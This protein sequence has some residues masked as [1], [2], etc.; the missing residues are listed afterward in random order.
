VSK[1][2]AQKHLKHLETFASNFLAVLFNVYTQTLPE[3]RG[4]ILQCIDAYLS[5][6]PEA[7][8]VETF[9][10]V[11]VM[12]EGSLAETNGHSKGKSGKEK[13][14]Q[15][16]PLSS[17][18]MDLV[19]TIALY[20]PRSGMGQLF[21]LA[22]AMLN[23]AD[24]NLQK[25]AYKIVPR[26]AE[27]ESGKQALRERTEELQNLILGCSEK[28]QAAARRER[29]SSI[30]CLVQ[31]LPASDL[32][33]IPS[34]LPEVVLCT[35]EINEKTRTAAFE[36]LIAMGQVMQNGGTILNAKIPH[37]P[38]DAP[39]AVASIEEFLTMVSAGLAGTA[40]H[41]IS[42]CIA[43]LT[44]VV[45][46]FQESLS[47]E[48]LSE[49][50]QT[51]DIF[52][53]SANREIVR[54]VLGFVKLTITSLPVTIVQPRLKTLIPNLLTWSHEHKAHVQS[55]VKHIFERLVRRFG[56]ELIEKLTPE[57]ERKLITNI[58]K[59]KDRSKRKRQSAGAGEGNDSSDEEAA[60]TTPRQKLASGLD[61]AIYGSDNDSDS[62]SD[63]SDNELLGKQKGKKKATN[64]TY[65]V[66]DDDEPLDLLD[67]K[68]L[69]RISTTAPLRKKLAAPKKRKVQVD[70]DG[71]LILG[72]EDEDTAMQLDSAAG[73]DAGENGINAYVEAIKGG[74]APRKGQRGKLKFSNKPSRS[75]DDG[76][77]EMEVDAAIS[78]EDV[79][80][81][82]EKARK[83]QRG[84]KVPRG[85][86]KGGPG[87]MKAQRAQRRGL[88]E[89]KTR[90]GRVMKGA[91]SKVGRH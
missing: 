59:A 61:E 83:M 60:K 27:S 1:E 37:M 62:G 72:Q 55:K 53:Q 68:A 87:G 15:M 91:G 26:L 84:G 43:A 12:L 7:D 57:S 39:P 88:Y 34:V 20:L 49:L 65:I 3:Y 14:K 73:A 46:E 33:F 82:R 5:I 86:G 75:Q 8:V 79:K 10:R 45:Y 81:A 30:S 31:N 32:H 40:P 74:N 13:Q 69:S 71:K 80:A 58:R 67:K 42:A 90:G 16:P 4:P 11:L 17:T 47:E 52:L 89:E 36:L 44:R 19:I 22:V 66:E 2:D 51:M 25:K 29:L 56:V 18:L 76:D 85:T 23:K 24:P 48:V 70:L 54:T 21:G 38:E 6:T 41:S 9:N 28:V 63:V 77:E 64:G 50:V 78:L 35:K